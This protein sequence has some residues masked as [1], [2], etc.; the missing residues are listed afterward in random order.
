MV[1]V[2]ASFDQSGQAALPWAMVKLITEVRMNA[3]HNEKR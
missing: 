2:G 1:D 3:I